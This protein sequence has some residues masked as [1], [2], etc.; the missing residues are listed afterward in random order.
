MLMLSLRPVPC[1]HLFLYVG[2]GRHP[3]GINMLAIFHKLQ[4]NYFQTYHSTMLTSAT[5]AVAMLFAATVQAGKRGLC[6]TYCE[7]HL[8]L[9]A[10]DH[11]IDN[12]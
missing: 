12:T 8:N 10:Q 6:W 4:V 11:F 2:A 1:H 9:L 5:L 3:G 7:S